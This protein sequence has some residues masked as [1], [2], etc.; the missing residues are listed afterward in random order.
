MFEELEGIKW[1]VIGLSEVR[2]TG[3]AFTV[4]KNGHVLC[5][6]GL[7][8]KRELGVGFLV[9]KSIAGNI[10]EYY[11]IN[12]RAAGLVIRL[13][14]RYK[15]K[16]VQGY[17]PTSSH[18]DQIVERFYEDV[19]SAMAKVKTQYTV[20]MGDFNAKV[21]KKQAGDKAVGN[22]GLGS[23]NNRGDLLVEFAERNNLR[24]M[25]TFF[26]K[27][28]SRKWT[29]RSPNGE[30][31]NEIDFILCDNP[32]VVQD[33]E[34][35]GRVRCSDHR[36]VRSRI[37]L[38]LTRDRNKLVRKKPINELSVRRKVE[39]FRIALQNRYSALTEEAELTTQEV[40]DN[41]TRI[42]TECAVEVGGTL[43][44]QDT[45]KLSQKT[46]DLIRKRQ[47][48]KI[49]TPADR[50]EL[51]ELSKL[52]NRCKTADIR[53][54]NMERIEHAVKNGGSLKAVKRRLGMGKNQMY[55]L[56]DKQGNVI[57][58]RDK[59]VA[60]AEEFYRDLYSSRDIQGNTER[61]SSSEELD[62]P[63]V[64]TEEVKKALNAM[65]GGKSPGED[66][67]TADLL[68]DG[69]L[70][71]LEKLAN[72][73]TQCLMTASVP[74]SWKNANIILI[75]KKG[76]MKDLK[77]YRPI[78]LL[79]V[80]YKVLTKVI[81]NRISA[82]LDFSQPNE[83]AGFRKGY[84]TMDHIH[85][86]NQVIE[87]CAE[88]NQPLYIAF[89]DYE[90]AFDSVETSAVIQALRNQGVD[91]HYVRILEDIYNGS[92]ATIVLHK[93]SSK[94]PIRKGVRQGDTI[95]PM[96]FTACLQEVFRTLD[97]EQV[98]VRVNGEYLS[99]LRF[100]D[101]VALLS[102]SGDELQSMLTALD[103]QSR[104]VGLKINM[105]KTKVILNNLGKAQ[106]FEIGGE[107]VEV[108]NEYVYLGQ[109]VTPDPN[110][111]AEII[112]RIRMG[113]SAFGRHSQIMNGSLPLSLKKKVYDS[114]ILP[115]LT[116]GAETWRLT[117]RV[118]L[119]LRTTQRAM[120]RKMVGVTL[121]DKKRAE[122]IREQT[123]VKDIL[124]E[125]KKKKW[126]WAGHVMRR[127]DNR[128]SLRVT[129]WIPREGKR[130]RGRPKVRWADEIKKF[131]GIKW[132]QLAQDRDN[133]RSMG[134]AFALQWA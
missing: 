62:I 32:G 24:I 46:K 48:M 7:V 25:N 118:Q 93:E 80:V 20:V 44:R 78:S 125:I 127:Q 58:N 89:I 61:G 117:K 94:I 37:R 99:N 41:L 3:E 113:W 102:N 60:V 103:E 123:R 90:K 50:I 23:R 11:S 83:Q 39:E 22:Y 47:S 45:G 91:E 124:V 49:S 66:Q 8:D 18:D 92:T 38:D 79:S 114:C 57:T 129:E 59:I 68:K 75:H 1:D 6:R 101:D 27:R 9:H 130:G 77:N 55:A 40:S 53:K 84:S 2:R 33:V 82:T 110:H 128:W 34:V 131:A 122:W 104:T 105:Q 16:V 43:A 98:G 13:N 88:Y 51:A 115:V 97:W 31:K 109:V 28:E 12:E 15:L 76:D 87:K 108:V 26:C 74:E 42:V 81:A 30:H 65:Q 112:R 73:Y 134:E 52:I 70:I 95:S 119:K 64:T 100:A 19:E 17:A 132:S 72:L 36:V 54:Y 106:R 69:G 5:Y 133:W 14:K 71:V 35:L 21:G 67:I 111:E 63:P 56:K 121:R 120:E 126:V 116:Y 29:W 96:L 10:D 85:T 4:L 86:I 107:A